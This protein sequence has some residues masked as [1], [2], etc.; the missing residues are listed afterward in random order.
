MHES[1]DRTRRAGERERGSW[2]VFWLLAAVQFLVI[3]D[4][5]IVTIALPPIQA[6]LGFS[7]YALP[8]VMDAYMLALGG[9]VLV[10]GKV[11]DVVGRRATLLTGIAIFTVASAACALAGA[12]W[13][14][15]AGRAA[16]GIGAALAAPAA[17]AHVT[18]LFTAGT[19][20]NKAMALW[21]GIGGVAGPTGV[22]LGGALSTVSWQLIFLINLPVGAVIGVLLFRMVGPARPGAPGRVDVVSAL[23]ATAGLAL[24]IYGLSRGAARGWEATATVT[25][26][27][28]VVILALFVWRQLVARS[29]LLP[30]ALVATPRFVLGAAVLALLGASLYGTF[31]TNALHLQIDRGFG[32]L[33]AAV[34][35]VPLDVALVMGSRVAERFVD[36]WGPER[37][38]GAGLGVQAVGLAWLAAVLSPQASVGWAFLLPGCLAC[39]G[40]GAAIVA[41]FLVVASTASEQTFGA[42]SGSAVAANQIGGAAGIAAT[43]TIAASITPAGHA[44]TAGHAVGLATA[45]GIA[46]LGALLALPLSDRRV[47]GPRQR[48]P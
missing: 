10:G 32:P 26:A 23:A 1:S 21:G 46:L 28:A 7:P 20:R 3:L 5:G 8:W 12:P 37:V 40:L 45:A 31:V 24:L 13:L 34:T 44:T 48:R 33:L 6:H 36:R 35:M 4:T 27:A 43:A 41:V 16:Q 29:P 15:V 25:V 18:S 19:G 17:F 11:A 39:L 30:R 38:L 2:P 14:L 47:S 9:F 42:V 22:L